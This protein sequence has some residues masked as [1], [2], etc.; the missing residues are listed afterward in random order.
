VQDFAEV[1]TCCTLNSYNILNYWLIGYSL[2]GRVA[3]FLPA[4]REGLRGLIV[5]G[6]HPGLQD[7][8]AA[9][10]GAMPRWA[11]VFAAS[12]WRRSLP[13]GIS[14]RFCLA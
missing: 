7:A 4:S 3:M 14:S 9:Q 1:N 13:T 5:E 8:R 11:S 6:G 2:G 10:R 12:R